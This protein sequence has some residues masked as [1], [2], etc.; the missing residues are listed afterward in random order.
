M[1]ARGAGPRT[2]P[3]VASPS[4][5]IGLDLLPL[6]IDEPD[7]RQGVELGMPWE[8]RDWAKWTEEERD[9]YLGTS[10]S[11]GHGDRLSTVGAEPARRCVLI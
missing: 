8:E 11:G 2:A 3:R 5:C 9:R 6:S 7:G 10:G 4:Y 1:A